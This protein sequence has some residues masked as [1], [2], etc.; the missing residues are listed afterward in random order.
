MTYIL[1]C[2][3]CQYS[4]TAVVHVLPLLAAAALNRR[5]C[6]EQ[7]TAAGVVAACSCSPVYNPP[8]A[9]NS[10]IVDSRCSHTDCC[11]LLLLAACALLQI[12]EKQIKFLRQL[13]VPRN[14][15]E[16]L[17][18]GDASALITLK[19]E[20]KKMEPPTE[21][22]LKMLK[23]GEGCCYT[24]LVA[25]TISAGCR[26]HTLQQRMSLLCRLTL[27]VDPCCVR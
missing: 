22:Q 21:A 18:K 8:P 19:V 3:G 10:S 2:A 24:M 7:D 12:T 25:L 23:V 4:C 20:E 27:C 26:Q 5:R 6:I 1:C 16:G 17:S 13:H 14:E 9:L 11:P 15:Y